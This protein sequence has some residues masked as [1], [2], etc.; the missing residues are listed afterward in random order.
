MRRESMNYE[1]PELKEMASY[2]GGRFE[3]LKAFNSDRV[4]KLNPDYT[5]S[6]D[7]AP[8]TLKIC[9]AGSHLPLMGFEWEVKAPELR[10]AGSTALCTVMD[11]VM[12]K[13]GFPDDLFK[14]EADCTVD[15]EAITQTFTRQWLRNSYKDF[16]AA[17]SMF[18]RLGITTNHYDCGM[19]INLD[20]TNFGKDRDAQMENVRKMGFLINYHYDFFKVALH[21]L[22]VPADHENWAPRMNANMDYWKTT[23]IG[24][25]PTGHSSCCV[26]MGHVRQGRVEIRLVG[27]QR[28]FPCFRN[29][30]ETMFQ[31]IDMVK[32]LDW[33]DLKDLTKVFKGCNNYVFSRLEENCLRAGVISPEAIEAIRP[34]VKRVQMI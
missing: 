30:W 4:I 33:E 26:N 22:P 11:L 31:M 23:E 16:K 8:S 25:F 5:V 1:T 20:L 12:N 10:R 6:T 32:K 13:A 15:A 18:E 9:K 29:T 7:N 2:H 27:G 34:T 19:H 24:M 21:R 14:I 28:N 17:Y 3:S